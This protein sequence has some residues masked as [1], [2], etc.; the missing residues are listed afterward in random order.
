MISITRST[1]RWLPRRTMT[2]RPSTYSTC[3]GPSRPPAASA[4]RAA[5]IAVWALPGANCVVGCCA[6]G[7]A[8]GVG[9]ASTALV[10][11][12]LLQQGDSLR[13]CYLRICLR[14]LQHV[15]CLPHARIAFR[16][17]GDQLRD[18]ARCGRTAI[19][20]FDDTPP[21]GNLRRR[22]VDPHL[23]GPRVDVHRHAGT[24]RGFDRKT[25]PLARRI[26]GRRQLPGQ[27][28]FQSRMQIGGRHV[29]Q[30]KH[31][32][33]WR[34]R[35]G[36]KRKLLGIRLRSLCWRRRRILL[37]SQLASQLGMERRRC[38]HECLPGAFVN[39][40][41]HVVASGCLLL[42]GREHAAR[43]GVQ[44][45]GFNRGFAAGG[46]RTWRCVV[47][48]RGRLKLTVVPPMSTST[49][50][51]ELPRRRAAAAVAK[52][53]GSVVI[54]TCVAREIRLS[55]N[56]GAHQRRVGTIRITGII[57]KACPISQEISEMMRRTPDPAE[58]MHAS[59][60][61]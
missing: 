33:A 52:Q 55:F 60:G 34:R 13:W 23:T 30:L 47:W 10:R 45:I 44:R 41:A 53:A 14:L 32:G 51:P 35:R 49:L 57:G 27:Q 12:R 4:K 46:R 36:D 43:G 56:T 9:L 5:S 42:P 39:R 29:S 19:E 54:V 25:L 3:T 17:G 18:V 24:R 38:E 48:R 6:P 28:L 21:G 20:R 59:R 31:H 37:L 58:E 8:G 15:E 50:L 61:R 16:R 7:C 40:H 26:G 22:A 11:V 2:S 1:S